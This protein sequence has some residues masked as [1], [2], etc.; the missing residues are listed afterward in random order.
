MAVRMTLQHT[1][2][3][4]HISKSEEIPKFY[5]TTKGVAKAI[6]SAARSVGH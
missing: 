6:E 2:M 4:G 3:L 5:E 1:L